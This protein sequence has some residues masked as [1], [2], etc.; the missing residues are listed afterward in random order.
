MISVLKSKTEIRSARDEMHRS[1]ISCLTPQMQRWLNAIGIFGGVVVG[2]DSKSWDVLKT[3][4]FLRDRLPLDTPI[5]DVGAYASEILAVLHRMNFSNLAGVDLNPRIKTMPFEDHIRY[6]VGD[7]LATPFPDGSFGAI[8]AISVI[9]HG[10][11]SDRLLRELSRL[12][13]PGGYFIASF[14]YWPE[15]V[16][17][18]GIGIF[19]MDWRI[20]SKADVLA[21]IEEAGAYELS[22]C[23]EI[24]LEGGEKVIHWGGKDYTFAWLAIRKK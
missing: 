9:E 14:D 2:D 24:D 8:T 3:A 7:F 4:T 6:E 15:K 13:R 19:G 10:F 1:G 21:F 11:M 16:D 23:G 5:L 22:P 18:T 17:T 12:L 20:F